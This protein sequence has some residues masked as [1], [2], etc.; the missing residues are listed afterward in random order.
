MRINFEKL[1]YFWDIYGRVYFP[2]FKNFPKLFTIEFIFFLNF[3]K[4]VETYDGIFIAEKSV[5]NG[6]FFHAVSKKFINL[7]QGGKDNV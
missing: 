7:L 5:F 4:I 1:F 2:F 6:S 3:F